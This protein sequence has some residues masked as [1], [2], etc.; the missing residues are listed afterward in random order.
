M[1]FV[2]IRPTEIQDN[3]FKLL[4]HDWMLI[5]AGCSSGWN[6]MTAS[7]GGLGILWGKPVAYIFIRPT[8]H[9]YKFTES[10]AFFTCSFFDESWR[11]ALEFCGSHSGRDTDKAAET[12]LTPV[13]SPEGIYFEQSR[14]ALQCRKIY[15]HDI[16]PAGFID[17]SI[18]KHY[19]KSDYHRM[20]IGE[21]RQCLLRT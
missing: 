8:R 19:S 14:L 5:T 18:E 9:T 17:P 1:S 10:Q 16:T 7:W 15:N 12:G 4:D 11:A 13:F 6:T 21:I 3:V 2:Q 20:Y